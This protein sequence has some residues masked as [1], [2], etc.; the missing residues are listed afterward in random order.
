MHFPILNVNANN[1]RCISCLLIVMKCN[2][3]PS[4]SNALLR[5]WFFEFIKIVELA[6]V[7]IMGLLKEE[8]MFSTF[9]FM[10]TKLQNWFCECLDLVVCIFAQLF[11]IVNIF[12][13]DDVITTWIDE[14]TR[15]GLLALC[16]LASMP[17]LDKHP[18][19]FMMPIN[20]SF[21]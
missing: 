20:L 2:F 17:Q 11:Y 16:N 6:M 18:L 19:I 12:F 10:K 15:R 9:M 7:Q 5:A 4:Y 14:K 3:M 13:H 8:R 21:W 1:F